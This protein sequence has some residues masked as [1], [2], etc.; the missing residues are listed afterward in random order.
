MEDVEGLLRGLKLTAAEKKGL[1][2]GEEEKGKAPGWEQEEPQAVG[3]LFS[4][5]LVHARVI[6]HTMGRIWC[7][8]KGLRCSELE[9]NIFL[10]TFKQASGWRRALEDGPWWFDKELLVMEEFDPDKMV[11]KY[12]FSFI[13]MWIRV[14]GLPVGSM[15]RAMREKIGKDFAKILDVDVG[16]DGKAIGKFLRIKECKMKPAK[17]EAPQFGPWMRAED[18]NK[19]PAEGARGKWMGSRSSEDN[20]GA[21]GYGQGG[22]ERRPYQLGRGG[23]G[24][25]SAALS[26]RKDGT[27]SH[28][29]GRSSH[30]EER[31][32]TSPLKAVAKDNGSGSKVTS[33]QLSFDDKEKGGSRQE[34]EGTNLVMVSSGEEI[35]SMENQPHSMEKDRREKENAKKEVVVEGR[36][37]II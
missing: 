3:K 15:N 34:N 31:E 7:P 23:S 27:T 9:E 28:S 30:E 5:K 6:G 2:V 14:Y 20:M 37:K 36:G 16:Y 18:E 13:P 25:G 35:T 17:D 1:K 11:G 29:S 26:W 32:V 10:F 22:T 8:I 4:E 19:K 12:E 21:L 33:K 24:R